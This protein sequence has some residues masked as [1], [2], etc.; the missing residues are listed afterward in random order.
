M[1]KFTSCSEQQYYFVVIPLRLNDYQLPL[2]IVLTL[3][4]LDNYFI[5]HRKFHLYHN[6]GAFY[7]CL[8]RCKPLFLVKSVWPLTLQLF[9]A[10]CKD[11]E[12]TSRRAFRKTCEQLPEKIDSLKG[13]SDNGTETEV[14][15]RHT[16]FDL[17]FSSV[18]KHDKL[19]LGL[20]IIEKNILSLAFRR[21]G[22]T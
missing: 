13:W 20:S 2:L 10:R 3:R 6:F 22:R 17:Q 7:R 1:V 4:R 15:C 12:E 16:A 9:A 8:N 5:P 19:T 14:R 18:D 11:T 21:F